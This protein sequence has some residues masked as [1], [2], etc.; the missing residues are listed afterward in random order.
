MKGMV[1][2]EFL[3][4]VEN[5]FGYTIADRIVTESQLPSQGVYTAVGT[6]NPAE[7]FAL[8]GQLSKASG[9]SVDELQVSFGKYLFPRFAVLYPDLLKEATGALELLASLENYVHKEVRKLYPDAEL[10]LFEPR[11]LSEHCLEL[12]YRSR[13]AMGPFA[14]GLILACGEHFNTP[15]EVQQELLSDDGSAVKF[16]IARV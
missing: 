8:I 15:L 12:I 13:R 14:L 10:P 6:Y 7:L 11:Y 1:F 3:H 5:A 4:M 2:T 16:T 9:I